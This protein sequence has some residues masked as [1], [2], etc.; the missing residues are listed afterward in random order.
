MSFFC[1]SSPVL[2]NDELLR[3]GTALC[4][5]PPLAVKCEVPSSSGKVLDLRSDH[6]PTIPQQR[7]R[8]RNDADLCVVRPVACGL[9]K[10]SPISD[11]RMNEARRTVR[12]SASSGG[13]SEKLGTY[14][15]VDRYQQSNMWLL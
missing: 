9:G 14:C 15:E 3:V 2:A 8:G 6:A 1:A 10:T 7:S 4:K 11:L 12:E 5:D 13:R